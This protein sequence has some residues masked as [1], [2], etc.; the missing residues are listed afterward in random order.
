LKDKKALLQRQLLRKT[1]VLALQRAEAGLAG[2][3]GELVGRVADSNE[4]IARANQR[5]AYLH[6]TNVQKAVEELRQT[7]TE[8]DD[9]HEQIGAALDVV[10]RVEVRAPV[11]GVIVKVNFHTAGGVATPGATLLELL[12]LQDEL[13]IRAHIKPNDIAYVREGQPALVRLSALNRRI[14]PMIEAKVVYLSADA[15]ADQTPLPKDNGVKD[16]NQEARRDFYVVR[17][18]LD[19]D[20]VRKRLEDFRPTPGMPADVY[21]KT[22]ERTFFEY[23]MKP[24]LDSFSRAFRET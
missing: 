12:P 21:I 17:V 23:I 8:L 22:G 7:E 5:I 4:R 19:E 10:E 11:R 3:L 1:E 6:A 15:L 9:I 18:R 16:N 14:T 20:D 24:V 2:D 13:L